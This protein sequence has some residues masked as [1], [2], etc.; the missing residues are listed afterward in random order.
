MHG[1]RSYLSSHQWVF[2]GLCAA[3]SA[4]TW[5]LFSGVVV[6]PNGN[7]AMGPSVLIL[8]TLGFIAGIIV[9]ERPWR[10][11]AAMV[12]PAPIIGFVHAIIGGKL[13]EDLAMVVVTLPIGFLMGVPIAAAAYVGR[14]VAMRFSTAG[15]PARALGLGST[16]FLVCAALSAVAA[17]A[18]PNSWK[19]VAL[20]LAVFV[21]GLYFGS[22][23]RAFSWRTAMLCVG[24]GQ[25]GFMALVIVDSMRG[26][27][28]H[29]M[30]PFELIYIFVVT[31]PAALFSSWL[32][33][34]WERYRTRSRAA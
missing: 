29:N 1:I 14:E 15:K 17:L 10:W 21:C 4:A 11:A 19:V 32:G 9:P 20:A 22:K 24:A 3:G 33:V 30:L 5:L 12:L 31:F 8:L 28:N 25:V 6:E 16:T 27:P 18:P 13:V 34:L 26:G 7:V 2:A 23:S